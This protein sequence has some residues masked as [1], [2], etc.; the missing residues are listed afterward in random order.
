M[1]WTNGG[2]GRRVG[3][4]FLCW[5]LVSYLTYYTRLTINLVWLAQRPKQHAC[6]C[7]D[8][9]FSFFLFPPPLSSIF[10][11]WLHLVLFAPSETNWQDIPNYPVKVAHSWTSNSISAVIS[12]GFERVWDILWLTQVPRCLRNVTYVF[13]H[14][15]RVVNVIRDD[16]PFV[17]LPLHFYI[18][19][20][21]ILLFFSTLL[22]MHL[23]KLR[24]LIQC[25]K[26]WCIRVPLVFDDFVNAIYLI[27]V[28]LIIEF[29]YLNMDPSDIKWFTCNNLGRRLEPS[30]RK[31]CMWIVPKSSD[32]C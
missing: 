14:G 1:P 17:F 19:P 11:S 28:F 7:Y 22:L 12:L 26:Q 4:G 24:F 16:K 29:L 9:F 31:L 23:L 18:T 6:H 3:S 30:P 13:L 8:T 15:P 21:S 27:G 5:L 10:L 25:C 20:V 2:R 32:T